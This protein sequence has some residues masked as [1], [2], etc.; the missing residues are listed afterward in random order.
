MGTSAELKGPNF[1]K[2]VDLSQLREDKSLL[3]YVGEEA[4]MLVR[5]DEE[6][7]AIG[8]TCSHYGGP[9]SEGLVVGETVHCPW[10]HACFD[11]RTGE[12]LKA[13]ALNPVSA[14]NVEVRG[15]KV[16]VTGKKE[17][18]VRPREWSESQ[19]YVIVGSGAAGTA[20]AIM[21]RKQGFIGSITI[22]SEDKSL[23]YDRP[24]L[25]KD[26][27]AGNVPEDWVP[28]ET[29][30]F[31][32]THKIHFEL[33][34][35][36]EKVDAHRRS[37]FLSNGKTL[38]YDRL[39]LA[40]GGDPIHPPIPGIKQDHVFYLRTLQDC[41]RIIGRTSWAQKVVI[42]GAGFIG[43]EVAAALR[44]RN[45]EVH[46]VA[47][48]EMPLLKV[49][50]VHVGSVLHKLHEEHGV[51]F[52]LGH[53]IKEIRQRS[54]LLDDGHS[55]DCDFVIVGTGI[56]PNTQLAEQAGCWVENG[57]LVNEYLETSVP[58]IF[59]AGDIARWP[60]PH[61]Q[62]SIR[63]EHWEVAERQGQT[64]ALNMMGDRIKFQDVPF[65]WTQHYDLSLGYVGHSD[66]FDRMDVMGDLNSRDFAVAYYEDQKV[67][68]VLTLGRDR[69]SLLVEEAIGQYDEKKIHEIFHQ[70]ERDHHP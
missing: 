41:R 47:P 8:A 25:S 66:R 7:F 59:A 60:D 68:A 16:F 19:R 36:A 55:V 37:V 58:G 10:H 26:Y 39:L 57:V 18:T 44:Q 56:R 28:L 64:A 4:V 51:I 62:R 27:L 2:G 40:T 63:V 9:L 1:S 42:V 31:Y 69:E 32:Q 35:K 22:V 49:V 65:F 50:G 33:S 46:V 17:S 3:G 14:Y 48:E 61:S 12:A 38:R 6:Y 67:A 24:N 30:E 70:H 52:H 20:A 15:S 34:T 45:L 53:T 29:E 54:V 21:L 23:P 5:H 11:L 13:P 43:L